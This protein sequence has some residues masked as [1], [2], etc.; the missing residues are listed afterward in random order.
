MQNWQHFT[1]SRFMLGFQYPQI[2]PQGKPV[3]L[4]ENDVQEKVRVHI[5]SKDS[6]EVY[7]EITK[8]Q[9]LSAQM[10]YERHKQNLEQRPEEFVVTDLREIH[11]MSQRAY[12]Y[13]VRWSQGSRIVRLIEDENVTY[14]LLYDPKSPLNTQ[15]LLTVQWKY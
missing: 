8:Y 15:I 4:A 14:R 12:E 3:E 9:D 10:E 2:T 7:F 1:D 13:L 5:T 11:W 6:R